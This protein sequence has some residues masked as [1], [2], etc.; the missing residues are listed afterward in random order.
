MRFLTFLTG[1]VFQD[2]LQHGRE[3]EEA[4]SHHDI[5]L[6]NHFTPELERYFSRPLNELPRQNPYP[7]AVLLPLFLVAFAFNLLPFLHAFPGLSPLQHALSFFLPSL[8]MIGALI[9]TSVLLARGLTSG[10]AGFLALFFILLIITVVQAVYLLLAH[11]GSSWP[12]VIAFFALVLCRLVM[13]GKGFVLFTLYCRTQRL[14]RL[15][16]KMRLKR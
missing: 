9:I 15:A 7:V 4:I 5:H 10:L 13:N 3:L 12:L 8:V 2:L 11:H 14:A 6:L 16:R 1:K